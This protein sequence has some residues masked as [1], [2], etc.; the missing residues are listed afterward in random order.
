MSSSN[1]LK[2]IGIGAAVTGG[3]IT[4]VT[5]IPITLGFGGAGI[6]AGSMAAGIQAAI[7]N[8]AAQQEVHLLFVL[9]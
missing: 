3:I 7:G 4:G 5:L 1:I 8:V 9:H 2:K 6:I